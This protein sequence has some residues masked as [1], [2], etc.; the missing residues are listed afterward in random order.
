MTA[1]LMRTVAATHRSRCLSSAGR[2]TVGLQRVSLAI[3]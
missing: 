2:W 1:A 3:P